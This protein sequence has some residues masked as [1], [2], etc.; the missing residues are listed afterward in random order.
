MGN[1]WN[2]TPLGV[3][4]TP[5][6]KLYRACLQL[7]SWTAHVQMLCSGMPVQQEHKR[8]VSLHQQCCTGLGESDSPQILALG[9]DCMCVCTSIYNKYHK[10]LV[11]QVRHSS[12]T[13]PI[14]WK[15]LGDVIREL[16]TKKTVA[17]W[18]NLSMYQW[19]MHMQSFSDTLKMTNK[20]N[21]RVIHDTNLHIHGFS[22][23]MW[24]RFCCI[25][26]FN[27]VTVW[28]GFVLQVLYSFTSVGVFDD[29][30]SY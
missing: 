25:V 2:D 9:T 3:T 6:V 5:F 17:Q 18:L 20:T 16:W 19:Y 13:P 1:Q 8:Q 14:K 30:H 27:K 22:G 15:V 11:Y 7:V 10:V 12:H 4:V 28:L 24:A 21:K 29:D 23:C 26:S